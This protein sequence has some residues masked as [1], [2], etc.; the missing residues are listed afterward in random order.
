MGALEVLSKLAAVLGPLVEVLLVKSISFTGVFWLGAILQLL[1]IWP[2]CSYPPPVDDLA[3]GRLWQA[4]HISAARQQLIGL[5]GAWWETIGIFIFWPIL[6]FIFLKSL[7]AVGYIFTG[8]T[9]ISLIFIYVSGWIFDHRR[10]RRIRWDLSSG[11]TMA[12]LW[13]GRILSFQFPVLLVA[14]EA[15]GKI[16]AGVFNTLFSSLLLLRIRANNS[17]IY[18]YNRQI[19]YAFT[20]IVASLYILLIL[21]LDLSLIWIMA[22]FFVAGCLALLFVKNRRL[23]Y[24]LDT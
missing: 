23:R 19:T 20:S 9:L 6:L 8:A 16:A 10:H 2:C 1:A 18:S 5:C 12:V 22:S 3:L 24:R 4:W 7:A 14:T 17:I 11:A 13:I 15:F 21:W